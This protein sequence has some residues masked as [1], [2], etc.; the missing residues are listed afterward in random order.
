MKKGQIMSDE[1]KLKI[2]ASKIGQISPRKGVSLTEKT[3]EKLRLANIGK[4]LSNEI[5]EKI[6]KKLLGRKMTI[7]HR[8]KIGKARSGCNSNFWKGGITLKHQII[9]CCLEYK[10]WRKAVFERDNYTCQEC[11]KRGGY[12]EAHHIKPFA[13]YPDLIFAIDNGITLCKNCHRKTDNYG[14]NKR[15][16]K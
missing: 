5:K 1:Q 2:S 6:R 11:G 3:K 9:R 14:I 8:K 13:T 12:V 4:K 16:Q 15:S 10:L 7:E